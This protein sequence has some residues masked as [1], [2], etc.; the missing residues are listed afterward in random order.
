M[1]G[2]DI[3]RIRPFQGRTMLGRVLRGRCPRLVRL[4]AQLVREV[5]AVSPLQVDVTCNRT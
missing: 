2:R 5:Y 1:Y 3:T 4:R